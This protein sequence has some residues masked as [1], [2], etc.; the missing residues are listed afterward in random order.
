MDNFPGENVEVCNTV[1]ADIED[2]FRISFQLNMIPYDI[3]PVIKDIKIR[4]VIKDG[5]EYTSF[6]N[7]DK[8]TEVKEAIMKRL[9]F[10]PKYRMFYS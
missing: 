10:N 9:S 5:Q 8:Q 7:E 1:D 2:G 6:I 3:D 4:W